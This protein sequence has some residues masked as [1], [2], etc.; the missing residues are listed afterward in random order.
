MLPY[1]GQISYNQI[2]GEFGSPNNFNLQSAYNG[3]YAPLNTYSYIQPT[4]PGGANYSPNQWYGYDG[5]WI[6]TSNLI[7]NYDAWP[8]VGSYPGFGT[9]ITNT[10]GGFPPYDGTLYNGTGM[11]I[12]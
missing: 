9:N 5:S 7:I 1:N 4:N 3:D 2:R 11:V 8:T 6:V 12:N 10:A